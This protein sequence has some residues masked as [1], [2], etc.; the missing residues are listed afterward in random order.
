MGIKININ[1]FLRFVLPLIVCTSI[2]H[3]RIFIL[4]LRWGGMY[5]TSSRQNDSTNVDQV[6]LSKL[7]YRATS[8]HSMFEWEFKGSTRCH[9]FVFSSIFMRIATCTYVTIYCNTRVLAHYF[10]QKYLLKFRQR[11][12]LL[13]H[14]CHTAFTIKMEKNS[15][16][17]KTNLWHSLCWK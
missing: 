1:I 7:H 10:F 13:W 12:Q 4:S 11:K 14:S 6:C 5:F 15:K 2:L 8:N 17:E 9:N 16:R 3:G